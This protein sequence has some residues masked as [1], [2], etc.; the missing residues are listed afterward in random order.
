M[1]IE[2][3]KENELVVYDDIKEVQTTEP[4][5]MVII[6]KDGSEESVKCEDIFVIRE[7]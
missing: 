3:F 1:I 6:F 5:K 2:Y 7:G 4:G